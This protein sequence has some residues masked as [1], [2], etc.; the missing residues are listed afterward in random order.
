MERRSDKLCGLNLGVLTNNNTEAGSDELIART[1]WYNKEMNDAVS[2]HD[3]QLELESLNFGAFG[4]GRVHGATFGVSPE[5]VCGTANILP[6]LQAKELMLAKRSSAA[7]GF[8]SGKSS[9][10]GGYFT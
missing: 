7:V 6:N 5:A 9:P 3:V 10:S 1:L 8:A 4:I 2:R